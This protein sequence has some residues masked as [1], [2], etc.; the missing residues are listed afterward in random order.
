MI[1]HI[2]CE[3]AL[4]LRRATRRER[5]LASEWRSRDAPRTRL[6]YRARLLETSPNRELARKLLTAAH[7]EQT[8]L[9]VVSAIQCLRA[10]L[11]KKTKNTM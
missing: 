4:R 11:K 5:E 1:A 9:A 8:E 3:Q 6:S 7:R 2:A 10:K